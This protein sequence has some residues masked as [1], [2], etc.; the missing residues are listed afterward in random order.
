MKLKNELIN[1]DNIGLAWK[2]NVGPSSCENPEYYRQFITL[3]AMDEII[4]GRSQTHMFIDCESNALAG[5]ISMRA[6]A[7]IL[8]C[9]GKAQTNPALEISEL[10]VDENYER[11]GVGTEMFSFA[12]LTAVEL[13][14]KFLGIQYIV[15][16]AD[17]K[18]VGFYEK[19]GFMP[20][21]TGYEIPRDGW[22]DN[23]IAMYIKLPE[24]N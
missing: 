9:E 22:N 15:V 3:C 2:F 8:L 16:C 5:Y 18:A 19:L 21:S 11:M 17:P 1:K 23:C 13:R 24:L 12:V 20:L 14:K 4:Q 7:L 10:A 6:S